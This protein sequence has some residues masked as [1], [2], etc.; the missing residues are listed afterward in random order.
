MLG[1]QLVNLKSIIIMI[2]QWKA[3]LYRPTSINPECN[4]PLG[5][6]IFELY[7]L[8]FYTI[9]EGNIYLSG[10]YLVE[11]SWVYAVMSL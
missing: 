8:F 2:Q 11:K 4:K 7:F 1:N 9:Q 10:P 6:F 5:H 3:I